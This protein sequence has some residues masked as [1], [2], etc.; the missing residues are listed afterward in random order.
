[1]PVN[2]Q[3]KE[4]IRSARQSLAAAASGGGSG[5]LTAMQ[6][7]EE[8]LIAAALSRTSIS[9]PGGSSGYADVAPP[10][11]QTTS[12][13]EAAQRQ[14]GYLQQ[15]M[16]ARQMPAGPEGLPA[17]VGPAGKAGI[18]SG[19]RGVINVTASSGAAAAGVAALPYEDG[20]DDLSG[21]LR[22]SSVTVRLF[23]ALLI[24]RK[25]EAA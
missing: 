22:P 2:Q 19:G 4:A 6:Q 8:A 1:M 23:W 5:G 3:R 7:Q 21:P 14:A 17:G 9:P 15:F 12:A 10:R 13:A 20:T 25:W 11:P 18:P 16:Q 24:C